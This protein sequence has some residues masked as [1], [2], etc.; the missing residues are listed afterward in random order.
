M[1]ESLFSEDISQ[2]FIERVLGL[3]SDKFYYNL[4][5]NDK[6]VEKYYEEC[7]EFSGSKYKIK[8][9]CANVLKYLASSA[10]LRDKKNSAYDDCLLLNFW[11]YDKIVE[12]HYNDNQS[13]IAAFGKLQKVWNSLIQNPSKTLY[14][15]KCEPYFHIVMK[16]DWRK[17]KNLYDYCVD[18][19]LLQTMLLYYKEHCDKVYMYL[20][21][22]DKLYKEYSEHCS[23]P[24]NN[25]CPEFFSKCKN[26]DPN[27]LLRQL[28]CYED[29]RSK[30]ALTLKQDERPT[31]ADKEG[32]PLDS[33]IVREG[34]NPV[35]NSGNVLLGVVIT[36]M[37]SGALYK[38]TPLGRMLRNGLGFNRNNINVHD[39]GLFEYAPGSFNPYSMGG[40]EHYI[41]YQPA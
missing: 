17:R 25:K 40:D 2:Y 1:V 37:T 14:Y 33:Q 16:D 18:Y 22:K 4:N 23:N 5:H 30:E 31:T 7:N 39:N 29:M 9:I 41:G 10:K 26:K 12:K 24:D 36:S 27:N 19:D 11:I 15:D 21:E 28:T 6:D 35:T 8:R 32:L 3:H 20:K 13:V 34:T 38:F